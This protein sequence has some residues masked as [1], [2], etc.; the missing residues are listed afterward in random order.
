MRSKLAAFNE[1]CGDYLGIAPFGTVM[2]TMA[3][4]FTQRTYTFSSAKAAKLIGFRDVL[5]GTE[6][7]IHHYV[8]AHRSAL[9]LDLPRSKKTQ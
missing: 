9:G 2:S 6:D 8:A 7:A 5:G 3:V 1:F 4:T